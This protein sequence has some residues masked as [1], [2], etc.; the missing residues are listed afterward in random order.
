[1]WHDPW[2]VK[3]SNVLLHSD[4]EEGL[5][6]KIADFG[7]SLH[8]FTKGTL[9]HLPGHSPPWDAP[10]AN[11]GYVL[12]DQI[13][14]VDIYSWGMMTWR[15]MLDGQTPFDHKSS[16]TDNIPEA[17][18]ELTRMKS[19]ADR[20]DTIQVVKSDPSDIFLQSVKTT[21]VGRGLDDKE[22]GYMFT[23]T[24]RSK[25]QERVSSFDVLLQDLTNRNTGRSDSTW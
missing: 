16:I 13:S 19:R 11:R 2:D 10:K 5:I 25:P 15:L 20:L 3:T 1:V 6:A 8:D 14:K 21:I 12:A 9:V 18:Q 23:M 7:C 17:F 4:D 22:L 24:L